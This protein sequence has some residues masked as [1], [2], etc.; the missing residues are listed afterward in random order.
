MKV[1]QITFFSLAAMVVVAGCTSTA[2]EKF[3]QRSYLEQQNAAKA[4][5][6]SGQQQADETQSEQVTEGT[7]LSYLSSFQT[8]DQQRS[9]QQDMVSQFSDTEM[10]SVT[11]DGLGLKDYLHYVLGELLQVSYVLGEGAEADNNSVTLNLQEPVSKKRLFI[12]SQEL[13]QERG[14]LIRFADGLF[15]VHKQEGRGSKA[16]TIFGYGN[17]PASVPETSMDIMQLVPFTYGMQ[18]QVG[19]LVKLFTNVDITPYPQRDVL[20]V[21]GKRQD[22]LKA[23]DLIS[24]MD[25]PIFQDRQIGMYKPT[26]VSVDIIKEAMPTLMEQEGIDVKENARSAAVSMVSLESQNSLLLFANTKDV[27]QR[28]VYWAEQLDKPSDTEER[29]YF[30][31]QPEYSRAVDLGESLKLLIDG[32]STSRPS[33][34]TSAAAESQRSG[35]Q[36]DNRSG[37]SGG[38]VASNENIKMVVDERANSLIFHTTGKEYKQ[39]MPLI[40]RLDVMPKQIALEVMIAEVTLTDRFRQ[41]VEFALS[42]GDYTLRTTGALGADEFGGLSYILTGGNGSLTMNLFQSD[43]LVNVLSRPSIVVRD[44]VSAQINVGTDIPVI[45]ETT[46]DPNDANSIARTSIDY[47][48]TGVELSVTPTVNAQGVVTMVID[49]SISSEVEDV[50]TVSGSPAIFERTLSTEVIASNGQTV[51]L[52]GLIS[53]NKSKGSTRVPYLSELPLLGNLFRADSNSGDKT[54][55]VVLVTPRII[56]NASEWDNLKRQL[57][58]QLER[59]KID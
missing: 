44:G 14:Y 29:Q 45:G 50:S 9:S 18:L 40:R 56:E 51:I 25:R 3:S 15:Y 59:I 22:I 30:I 17:D 43:S 36:S 16:D 1:I 54:E 41:G 42:R 13:L 10:V 35:S 33:R 57:S 11:A 21:K 19:N 34:S 5:D 49:Q 38:Y 37:S 26:Y 2:P 7:G 39:I 24:L 4:L 52:G 55:L 47:R 31:Y 23:L 58:S 46:I 20:M 48:K 28:A 32:D 12:L 8:E 27:I 53:E 6:Q